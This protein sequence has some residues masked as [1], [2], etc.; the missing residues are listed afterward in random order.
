MACL[1]LRKNSKWW[2]GRYQL[3]RKTHVKNLG[4]K[5]RGARPDSMGDRGSPSF[6]VSRGEARKALADL[7]RR[8]E[9]R[10]TEERLAQAVYEART[11]RTIRTVKVDDLPDAWEGI[12]RSRQPSHRYM[13]QCRTVLRRFVDFVHQQDPDTVELYQVTRELALSFLAA[14]EQRGVSNKTWNDSLKLL[15]G[16]FKHLRYDAGMLGSPFDEIPARASETIFRKPFTVEELKAVLDCA[17][18]Y[19][20][21]R[22]IIVAAACTAMR[23][24]DCCLLRWGDVDLREGFVT[25]KTSKTGEEADIP[26][27]PLLFDEIASRRRDDSEFVFPEQAEMY[28]SNPGGLTYRLRKVLAAA[29]FRDV[30]EL[31]PARAIGL[32]VG[33][34]RA[35][36]GRA[37]SRLRASTKK[38]RMARTFDLYIAGQTIN[39]VVRETGYGKGSVSSYLNELEALAQL[40]F[41]RH[42]HPRGPSVAPARAPVHEDRTR[43]LRRASLRDFHSFRTTWITLALTSNI[44]LEL[45]K[46]VTGHRT[47]EVV[48][49][50]YFRPHRQQLRQVL[51]EAMPKLLT[52]GMG[53]SREQAAE[54][55]RTADDSNWRDVVREALGL[56]TGG[57]ATP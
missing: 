50:H 3:D 25:V 17:D 30:D 13:T 47:V 53:S 32:P 49:K 55:L 16:A 29:G 42:K 15:R 27:F 14:E 12:P 1:E 43:G 21:I 22:P 48:M 2:Y 33:Q 9:E 28:L 31:P 44:P 45:V 19:S 7:V 26:L 36:V 54:L 52:D 57:T 35:K 8:L 39:A 18:R 34:V 20:F 46:K 41:I 38:E 10:V 23:R 51:Q 37:L 24:G 5:V 56:L 11:G 6:E 4:V 40:S